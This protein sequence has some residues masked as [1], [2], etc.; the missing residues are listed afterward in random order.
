MGITDRPHKMN[1]LDAEE[2]SLTVNSYI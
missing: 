2:S 1:Y